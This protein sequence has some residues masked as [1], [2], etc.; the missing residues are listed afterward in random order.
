MARRS[1]E[2]VP[3]VVLNYD[4]VTGAYRLSAATRT[5]V[6]LD[7]EIGGERIRRSV[8]PRTGDVVRD[9]DGKTCTLKTVKDGKAVVDIR[10]KEP[11]AV[12]WEWLEAA[13]F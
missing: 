2:L 9:A 1:A 6:D 13:P 3:G 4:D 8:D 7:I 11:I 12:K 10:T 5:D